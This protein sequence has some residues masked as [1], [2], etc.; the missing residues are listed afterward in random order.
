[1]GEAGLCQ[2]RGPHCGH[3]ARQ[4]SQAFHSPQ[5]AAELTPAAAHSLCSQRR[6]AFR[7]SSW[8][9]DS[10]LHVPLSPV[11]SICETGCTTAPTAWLPD[12]GC[13]LNGQDAHS[14]CIVSKD[15]GK[16]RVL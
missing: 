6:Q 8:G 1:M 12:G 10:H 4:P 2:R 7:L 13:P 15:A 11:V 14:C 5:S 9:W 3:S 16:A